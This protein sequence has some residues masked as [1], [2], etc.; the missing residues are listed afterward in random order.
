MPAVGTTFGYARA[1]DGAYLGYRVDGDGPLDIVIQPEWPGNI[2]LDWDDPMS[3]SSLGKLAAMG[4]LISHDHRGVGVSSRNVALPTLETRVSDLM[5]VLDEVHADRP[6]MIGNLSTGGVNVM[7]AAMHPDLARALVWIEPMARY[8]WD[9]DYPWGHR[10]GELDEELAQLDSWGTDRYGR[11]F[12][13]QEAAFGN[14][15]PETMGAPLVRQTR[16]ACTP[17]VARELAKIWYETDVRGVLSSVQAPTLLLVHEDRADQVAQARYIAD[18]MPAA[19]VRAMPGLAWTLDELDAWIGEIRRFVGRDLPAPP[20]ETVLATV[21]FTDIVGSTEKQAE[22]GD[23]RWKE[24]V[25]A[26][27]SLVRDA[28]VR[29]NGIENDTAGDGFYATFDGPARAVRCVNEIVDRVPDLGIQIRAGVHT[30]E[31][32]LIDGKV[33]GLAVSIGARVASE[34]GPSEVMVSQ[35]VKDLVAGSGL[36]FEDAGEHE[37]KGVPDRWRLYRLVE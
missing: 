24:L 16:G 27:H 33:G 7:A 17:D 4:R 31:C 35:T 28:L 15:M 21:A 10:R 32:E 20:S 9:S 19:E 30:G 29:W 13:E 14:V 23:R 26:H 6:V 5:C 18:L 1:S 22:L 34:A 8:A 25:L 2:D 3:A 37:L 36:V 11:W 12:L